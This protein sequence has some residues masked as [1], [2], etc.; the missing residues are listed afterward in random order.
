MRTRERSA[1]WSVPEDTQ[2]LFLLLF[3]IQFSALCGLVIWFEVSSYTTGS[4]LQ[5][6]VP[7]GQGIGPWTVALAAESIIISE[8]VMWVSEK[9]RRRRYMQGLAEGLAEGAAENQK[10]WEEWNRRRE[11]AAAAGE[12]FS[13]PPPSL[14]GHGG[15]V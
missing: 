14:N 3:A 15:P 5:I 11:A 6:V 7:I 10:K 2:T 4:W 12:E 9:Y 8:T 13:E 1:I